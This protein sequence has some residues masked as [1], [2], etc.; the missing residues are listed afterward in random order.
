MSAR[1]KITEKKMSDKIIQLSDDSFEAELIFGQ[2]GVVHV[3]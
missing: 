2:N 1:E 3:K